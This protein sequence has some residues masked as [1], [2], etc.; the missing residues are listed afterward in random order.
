MMKA[1]APMI[2]GVIWPPALHVGDGQRAGRHRV[3]DRRAG[4]GA[5]EGRGDDADLGQPASVAA[6]DHRGHVDEELTEAHALRKHAE[7]HEVEHHCGDGPQRDAEDAFLRKVHA[8]DVLRPVDARMLEDVDRHDLAEQRIGGEQQDDDR[9]VGPQ[10]PAH[11][12]QQ[13]E[14]QH[15]AGHYVGD[16]RVAAPQRLVLEEELDA[17]ELGIDAVPGGAH[18]ER[19]GDPDQGKEPVV[20]RHVAVAP[21]AERMPRSRCRAGHG[22]EPD[23]DEE[24]HAG[25]VNAHVPVTDRHA[26]AGGDIVVKGEN[27]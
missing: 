22:R 20:D 12:L 9:H 23:E 6:G 7:Q 27:D 5:E 24:Q 17:E 13:D 2:G 11:R 4:Y 16:C 3:G 21:P 15:R 1:A 26:N 14:D 8:A 19:R 10:G 25:Q 18:I